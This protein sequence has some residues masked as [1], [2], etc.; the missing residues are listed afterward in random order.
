[1]NSK[2]FKLN[3]QDFL[4]GAV[5]AIFAA[6]VFALGSVVNQAGFDVFSAD[7]AQVVATMI[8]AALA[9]FVGYIGK[10]FISDSEGVPF[11]SADK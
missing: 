11:G 8:N 6:V 1:M 4:K 10:N 7:W 3:G 2:L 5:S 9:A